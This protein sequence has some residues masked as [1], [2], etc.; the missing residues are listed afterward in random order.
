MGKKNSTI[1]EN[2]LL[3]YSLSAGACLVTV[4]F[5]NA[6][7]VEKTINQDVPADVE[8]LFIDM[9]NN[10]NGNEFKVE[11]NTL[12]PGTFYKDFLIY[13]QSVSAAI[14]GT[15]KSAKNFTTAGTVNVAATNWITGNS[16]YAYINYNGNGN[17]SVGDANR[18]IVV[19]FNDGTGVKY[20]WI[21]LTVNGDGSQITFH[22]TVYETSGTAAPPLPVELISFSV[23][24][25]DNS[26]QLLWETATEI[27]NY[28]FEIERGQGETSENANWEKIGFVLG[29]GNSNSPKSYS[30]IDNQ[31]LNTKAYYRLKQIDYDGTFEYFN[32]LEVA[33][34]LPVKANLFQNYPNPFNPETTINFNL[35]SQTSVKLVIYNVIGEM[36]DILIDKQMEAG[37]HSV[38][39]DGGNLPSGTYVYRLEAGDYVQTK[40]MLLIK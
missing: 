6:A 22:K 4:N 10:G 8:P 40:K 9:D 12:N 37:F 20:G 27:N 13:N 14:Y 39:F 28:G 32:S 15:G 11:T 18:F 29:N 33:A 19:R 24:I 3:S 21:N 30:F 35:N 1:L 7:E 34:G 36:V 2:R 5:L 23:N 16:A 25:Q 38:N 17:F 26:V 31:P